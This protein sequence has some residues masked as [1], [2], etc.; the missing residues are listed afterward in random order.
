[1]FWKFVLMKTSFVGGSRCLR[2]E[3]ADG[4]PPWPAALSVIGTA[5]PVAGPEN[6]VEPSRGL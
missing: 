4:G 6:S 2:T 3:G 5:L 1:M